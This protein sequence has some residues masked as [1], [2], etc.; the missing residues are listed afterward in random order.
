MA[1]LEGVSELRRRLRGIGPEILDAIGPALVESANAVR[2][3]AAAPRL[4]GELAASEFVDGPEKNPKALST[5]VTVGYTAPYAAY[6]HEGFH[7][8]T[9]T[10]SPPKWLEHA[11]DSVE[12]DFGSSISAAIRAGLD[13]L[14][15]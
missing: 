6:E 12:G 15:R 7:G 5:T 9:R 4:T 10:A 3:L 13:R 11:A 8:K 2:A 14:G 1:E